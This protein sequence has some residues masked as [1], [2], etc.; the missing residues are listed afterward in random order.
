MIIMWCL[1]KSDEIIAQNTD[2]QVLIDIIEEKYKDDEDI[3]LSWIPPEGMH[4]YY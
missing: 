2:M 3:I 1:L 4:F